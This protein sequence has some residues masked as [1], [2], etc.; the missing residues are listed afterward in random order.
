[1]GSVYNIPVRYCSNNYFFFIDMTPLDEF[2]KLVPKHITLTEDELITLRDLV[3][4]QADMVLET[5]LKDKA[6]GII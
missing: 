4:L 5:Y 3:D 2:K 1:M 6:D